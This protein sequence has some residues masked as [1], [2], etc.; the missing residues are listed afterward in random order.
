MGCSGQ[1]I[2][3]FAWGISNPFKV[4]WLQM[5]QEIMKLAMRGSERRMWAELE[6]EK[7]SINQAVLR[8]LCS[9]GVPRMHFS[10]RTG[11]GGPV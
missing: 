8:A 1:P 3:K 11:L 2:L 5:K 6:Q 7:T 9:V 10:K 4:E